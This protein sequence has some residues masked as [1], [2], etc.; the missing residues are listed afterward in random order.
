MSKHLTAMAIPEYSIDVQFGKASVALKA[1]LPHQLVGRTLL[2]IYH[3]FCQ[4]RRSSMGK[5][6][7]ASQIPE[8]EKSK[9]PKK[10]L[11]AVERGNET[12]ISS[13]CN[14]PWQLSTR[15]S[16]TQQRANLNTCSR[17][18]YIQTTQFAIDPTVS[19][20]SKQ[21]GFTHARPWH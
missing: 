21:Q 2:R 19:C 9:Q 5:M 6:V 16:I 1:G 20:L 17:L 10:D 18:L 3:G 13:G 14:A 11:A 7:P 12:Y 4:R 15:R 8:E